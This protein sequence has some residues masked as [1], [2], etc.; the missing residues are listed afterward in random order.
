MT[1]SETAVRGMTGS[2]TAVRGMTDS[3]TAVRVCKPQDET[4]IRVAS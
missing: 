2:E 1:G 3:E 4:S